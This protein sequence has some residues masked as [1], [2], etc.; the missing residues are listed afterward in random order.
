V[1]AVARVVIDVAVAAAS[2]ADLAREVSRK[3]RALAF[4]LSLVDR[5]TRTVLLT[6]SGRSQELQGNFEHKTY[7]DG[8]HDP[9]L[10]RDWGREYVHG[11]S[12]S[13]LLAIHLQPGFMIR[14]QLDVV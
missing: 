13:L 8:G 14:L 9:P 5:A 10:R 6:Y 2:G 1:D 3:G 12:C 4:S 7:W 11:P